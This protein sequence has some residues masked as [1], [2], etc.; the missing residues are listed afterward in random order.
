MK[1]LNQ[2]LFILIISLI[3][4]VFVHHA[5]ASITYNDDQLRIELTPSTG[6]GDSWANAYSFETIY[7]Y[8]SNSSNALPLIYMPRN[9]S[10][11]GSAYELCE[12]TTYW[13]TDGNANISS[14]PAGPVTPYSSSLS[15]NIT[16]NSTGDITTYWN[17]NHDWD[18]GPAPRT[19]EASYHTVDMSMAT[20]LEFW[21]YASN[22]A[23]KLNYFETRNYYS[24]PAPERYGTHFDNL[25]NGWQLNPSWQH[26][27][28]PLNSNQTEPLAS[29]QWWHVVSLF[30]FN[31]SG[32]SVGDYILID[33]L[34]A[35]N[36][37]P[38]PQKPYSNYYELN[39][40]IF[41]YQTTG[42]IYFWQKSGF[43][44]SD[45]AFGKQLYFYQQSSTANIYV[46]FGELNAAG[47]IDTS[48][49][50]FRDNS[51]FDK[52]SY[53]AFIYFKAKTIK[54][55]GLKYLSAEY[56]TGIFLY[57]YADGDKEMKWCTFENMRDFT[58][59]EFEIENT[60]LINVD[61]FWPGWPKSVKN[62]EFEKTGSYILAWGGA[63]NKSLSTLSGNIQYIEMG[64]KGEHILDLIDC[65]LPNL[66][67]IKFYDYVSYGYWPS[68]QRLSFSNSANLTI[69]APNGSALPNARVQIWNKT[70]ALIFDNYTDSTGRIPVQNLTTK[71][72]KWISDGINN[73]KQIYMT[74]P[75]HTYYPYTIQVSKSGYETYIHQ[76][77][78]GEPKRFE[79][80][81]QTD[82]SG[83]FSATIVG[84]T[85]YKKG[86]E[87]QIIAYIEDSSGDFINDA[88]C[89]L[90]LYRPDHTIYLNT[91]MHYLQRGI[92]YYNFT[93]AYDDGIWIAWINA[94]WNG[95]YSYDLHTFHIAPWAGVY[96]EVHHSDY[97]FQDDQIIFY[98]HVD[99]PDELLGNISVSYEIQNTSRQVV[100]SGNMTE[101]ERGEFAAEI[102]P[103]NLDAGAYYLV[104]RAESLIDSYSLEHRSSFELSSHSISDSGSGGSGGGSGGGVWAKYHEN[105]AVTAASFGAAIVV[106][107][108][109][110]SK[111]TGV[112]IR[113]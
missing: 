52:D 62:L 99:Y 77:S 83:P 113:T 50:L 93:T 60:V 73:Y 98:T 20:H 81:L 10:T 103:H 100:L 46:Q 68:T 101:Y 86:E 66:Q 107:A 2:I 51:F 17:K 58:P 13:S 102:S 31:I 33:G 74:N 49:T 106:I 48:V 21:I 22:S 112:I 23:M 94:S 8:Y 89:N 32:G 75:T 61:R 84:A 88:A 104:V 78:L 5:S 34:R 56:K 79:F 82:N 43:I 47:Y 35:Y 54:L 36:E 27:I 24:S 105:P 37:N 59:T 92:Y 72:Y 6:E 41:I 11:V 64:Y 70:G 69:L 28:I 26:I 38:N 63:F 3:A 4:I 57:S 45:L 29:R 53:N 44:Y 67:Y 97:Y 7:Q 111:L 85:E 14:G 65:D 1:V 42:D 95:N 87:A 71:D 96:L 90:T 15:I 12:N 19:T 18:G 16:R 25:D 109:G 80:T 9:N 91:S 55:Y 110:V 76:T 30:I 108:V 39:T 40:P